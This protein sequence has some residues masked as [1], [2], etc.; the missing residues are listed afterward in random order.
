MTHMLSAL[1]GGKMVIALEGGYNV[2]SISKS[3]LECVKVL[4]GETPP[5]LPSL[6]A[7]P[8]AVQVLH[9]V[10]QEQ[11]RHWDCIQPTYSRKEGTLDFVSHEASNWRVLT[12]SVALQTTQKLVMSYQS[13]VSES[14]TACLYCG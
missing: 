7:Q 5:P 13:Q 9:L 2:E 6:A 1:A 8:A 4:L 11:S 14:A 10:A 3:A 12:A